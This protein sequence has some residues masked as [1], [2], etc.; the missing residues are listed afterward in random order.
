MFLIHVIP[1]SR[2]ITKDRL[3]YFSKENLVP[4]TVVSVPIRKSLT[5]AIVLGSESVRDAKTRL[6]QSPYPI[7]KVEHVREARVF[8]EAFMAAAEETATYCASS[9]G[10]LINTLVP[11]AILSDPK[12]LE[13][14]VV[15]NEEGP[16]LSHERLVYQAD[17]AERFST[18]RGIMREAFARKQSVFIVM[19]TMHD[20]E[21]FA[22]QSEKGIRAY[23]FAFHSGLT[24]KQQRD[25][26]NKALTEKHPVI[27]VGTGSFLSLPRA[28]IKTIVLERESASAYKSPVRPYVDVR[29]FA[30]TFARKL[31]ARIIYADSFLRI[32][33][34]YRYHHGVAAEL[35]PLR[36]RPLSPAHQEVI[37]M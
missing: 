10:A 24:K 4:G 32:E 35:S 1:I 20:V 5:P 15:S 7:K 22:L 9:L 12:K 6:R 31:G 28:D 13:E 37:D 8:S 14:S 21:H 33:T 27:I 36:F 19:P 25:R 2:G 34:L 11:K 30:D 23:L 18:Y 16:A 29:V 26:W 17:R 3:S